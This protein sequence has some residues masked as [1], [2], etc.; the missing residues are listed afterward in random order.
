MP[1][2][3]QV[4]VMPLAQGLDTKTD[5][6]QVE[7]GKLL[8]LENGVFTTLRAIRKRN[9]NVALGR[10]IVNENS[11]VV[12]AGVGLASYQDEL[13]LADGETLFSYDQGNNG[14]VNK[15]QYVTV[16]VSKQSVIKD[17]YE[18]TYVD[19]VTH[20]S[21]IQAYVWQDSASVPASTTT[22]KYCIIDG[23]TNQ[24]IVPSTVLTTTGIKPK[25]LVAGGLFVFYFYDT[26][27]AQ[28][29]LATLSV[30][31][32]SGT[33]TI[34]AITASGASNDA[35][36]STYPNY[37]VSVV[38]TQGGDQIALAFNNG[39]AGTTLRLY[40]INVPTTQ[41][42][43]E[44]VIGYRS[45]AIS[46]F[47]ANTS[48]IGN[49]GV[50][51]VFASDN[52]SSPYTTTIRFY[53]YDFQLQPIQNG[54]IASGL[55]YQEARLITGINTGSGVGFTVFYS[56]FQT[57]ANY[58]SKAVVDSTYSV[59]NTAIWKRNV[60]PIGRAFAVN[61]KIYVPVTFYYPG[62]IDP[63]GGDTETQSVYF[64]LDADGNVIAKAL[65]QYAGN[66]PATTSSLSAP[67]LA[68]ISFLDS[69][70]VR[71]PVLEQV[72]I[73]GSITATSTNVSS[74]DFAF[75]DAQHAVNH[76]TLA[77]NLHLSGGFLSMYDGI[78]AVEHNFHLYP[79]TGTAVAGGT[80]YPSI[81]T[82]PQT[83][84]V[85]NYT[86]CFEWVDNQGNIHQSKPASYKTVTINS[87]QRVQISCNYL[88]LTA[89][90]ASRPI[91]IVFYRTLGDGTIFHR[92]SSLTAP[93]LN[94]IDGVSGSFTFTDTTTDIDLATRPQLY[95]QPLSQN[96][97]AE[98]ENYPAPPTN[99]MAL[100]RNRLFVMDSTNPLS[101]WY[102]KFPATFTP[103]AFN[104]AQVKQIDPRG[105]NVTALA[106]VDDKL[107]VFKRGHIFFIVGQGPDNTGLNNDFSD[108]ILIT[109]D[110]GCIDPRSVVGTPV[111]IM[112]QSAKGIYLIDRSLQVQYVGAP[113]EAYNSETIT[114]AT[115]IPNTNQVRFTL[116]SGKTLVFDYY[117]QQWGTFT[118][119]Y[120]IDSI[121]WQDGT[122]ILRSN[123]TTLRETPNV[124]T[125]AGS[126]IRL[127]IATSWLSFANVQ[128][129][130]RVRR[131]QILGG[132]K[133]AHNLLVNVC[134]DF[135]DNTI[136]QAVITPTTPTVYGGSSPYGAEAVY[137]GEFQLYQWRIDL[138]RQKC[139]A[140]KLIFE[141]VPVSGSGEGLNL[142][143]LGFEVGA[144]KG[145]NKMPATQIVS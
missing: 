116:K 46:V 57:T 94:V 2:D 59:T 49:A 31:N 7:A 39:N 123:G 61:E 54:T 28:I 122:I 127:K 91:Q 136:Q 3:R 101:L 120:A 19:G 58:A 137:G 128:G 41:N 62:A 33:P 102:S 8:E 88:S 68:T 89:K 9:G 82:A 13:L 112:F 125:D 21:G 80:G 53:S 56:Y 114:S 144:K 24:T 99:L 83:S 38:S 55:T 85:Y 134:V 22:I 90:D 73:S 77:N 145:L 121:V 135:N 105:G 64:L 78:K 142:T 106:T 12:T 140:V 79:I 117:V 75:N 63:T 45:R 96:A 47:E 72:L 10:Q 52:G 130:Q 81:P 30:S 141:D 34:T 17:T 11:A 14:W 107:L 66:S 35:P 93:D 5:V 110:C 16:S 131:A 87:G 98:V 86:A 20:S 132:F 48:S 129:F 139:Q 29:K 67:P 143:S 100:H 71:I 133:S 95:T 50:T 97:V 51:I 103:V 119:Q 104:D 42:V 36:D 15:D 43:T 23:A 18:Q 118:N 60:S 109:T 69:E 108:A 124:F 37:D 1:L 6:K 76:V 74:V 40:S 111:G 92:V 113:V 138:A 4:I 32:V 70:T 27:S 84:G 26:N 115:L 126:P 25:V 44:V 65:D